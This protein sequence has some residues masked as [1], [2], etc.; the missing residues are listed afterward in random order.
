MDTKSAVL[1][2]VMTDQGLRFQWLV[3]FDA[4]DNAVCKTR[5]GVNIS[6][7]DS[8]TIVFRSQRSVPA[9]L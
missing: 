9:Q 3:L 4:S 5:M 7:L 8:M 1:S 2:E 6:I